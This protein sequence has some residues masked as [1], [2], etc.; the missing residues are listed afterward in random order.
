ML[1]FD[2]NGIDYNLKPFGP[3]LPQATEDA[4]EQESKEV[5]RWNFWYPPEDPEK[6]DLP[7]IIGFTVQI[8]RHVPHITC[9]P[10]LSEEYLRTATQSEPVV[11][12]PHGIEATPSADTARLIITAPIATGEA[13][14]AKVVACTIISDSGTG[15]GKRFRAAAKIYDPLYYSSISDIGK[16]P[17]DCVVDAVEHYNT[18]TAAYQRLSDTGQTG[19]LAPEYHGSWE[20]SL[21]VTIKGKPC[22]RPIFLILIEHLNGTSIRDTRRWNDVTRYT[23]KDSYHY[24]EGF[25]LEVLARAMD[26]YVRQLGTG[27]RQRDFAARNVMLVAN[28][29]PSAQTEEVCGL[30]MPRIVLIDY[31]IAETESEPLVEAEKTPSLP[32]NPAWYFSG[33]CLWEDFAGWA[34]SEW[35]KEE[36]GEEWL[37]KRFNTEGVR[38]L[39]LPEPDDTRLSE[40]DPSDD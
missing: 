32:P 7:Y 40:P 16:Y 14:G 37:L 35:F 30:T 24:P 22:T 23:C 26:G 39:Y 29:N 28:D 1:K 12:N 33:T 5:S 38:E 9:R 11:A 21:P 34:P 36:H 19:C 27:V 18:E 25:R 17:Q 15:A 20:F 31:N 13:P 3:N 4:L 6:P 2:N 10:H 8:Q